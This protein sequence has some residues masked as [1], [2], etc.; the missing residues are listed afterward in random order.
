[1]EQSERYEQ[2]TALVDNEIADIKEQDYLRALIEKDEALKAEYLLQSGLKSLIQTR[3]KISE[4]PQYLKDRII[5]QITDEIPLRKKTV[6]P[7]IRRWYLRPAF[8]FASVAVIL[9]LA[10]L[11]LVQ[12]N[13]GKQIALQQSG[14]DNMFIQAK[15]NF[16]RIKN[17]ELPVQIF[18]SSTGVVKDFFRQKGVKFQPIVPRFDDWELVGGAVSDDKG[19]ILPHNVYKGKDGKLVYLYQANEECLK[20]EKVLSLSR[21]L[22]KMMDEGKYYKYVEGDRSILMWKYKGN[23]CVV[24]SDDKLNK[25]EDNFLAFK[26]K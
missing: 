8:A 25:L 24:V 9:L 11:F 12:G 1:M 16:Q 7:P 14:L 17:G 19:E 13:D 3:L 6:T 26:E 4:T 10:V 15:N 22:L 23:I 5:H 18:S 2:I 20:R 21:D